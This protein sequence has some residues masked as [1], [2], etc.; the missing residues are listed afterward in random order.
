MKSWSRTKRRRKKVPKCAACEKPIPRFVPD[1][2]LVEYAT[3]KKRFYHVR[4]APAMGK[5]VKPGVYHLIYR[6]VNPETN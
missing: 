6:D 2:V 3:G 1:T 5:L 4:C